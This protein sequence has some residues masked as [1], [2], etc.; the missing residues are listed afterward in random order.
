MKTPSLVPTA[1]PG[2]KSVLIGAYEELRRRFLSRQYGPGLT[3]LMRHGLREWMNTCSSYL[4]APTISVPATLQ[5]EAVLPQGV[6]AELVVILAG[7]LLHRCQE[8]S[9]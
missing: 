9:S 1:T 6:R 8:A 4:D 7:M 2:D 3:I 5:D